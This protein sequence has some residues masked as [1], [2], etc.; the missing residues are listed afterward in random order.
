MNDIPGCCDKHGF[1]SGLRAGGEVQYRPCPICER[2]RLREEVEKLQETCNEYEIR[3]G[4]D[5]E[6]RPQI[7]EPEVPTLVA[8]VERLENQINYLTVDHINAQFTSL[9]LKKTRDALEKS[10]HEA[11]EERLRVDVLNLR[12]VAVH[13]AGHDPE[14]PVVHGASVDCCGGTPCSGLWRPRAEAAEAEVERLKKLLGY[15]SGNIKAYCLDLQDVAVEIE[16]A[17]KKKG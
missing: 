2:D 12:Q 3:L 17:L 15:A 4:R 7:K 1:T 8:E 16:D 11:D 5:M 10:E 6:H 9:D 13:D 14:C